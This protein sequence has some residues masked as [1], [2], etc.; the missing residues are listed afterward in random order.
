MQQLARFVLLHTVYVPKAPGCRA[1]AALGFT[2][3]M[4]TIERLP[5]QPR[6]LSRVE[7]KALCGEVYQGNS[8]AAQEG[9]DI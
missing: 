6:T 5:R 9:M 2:P 4:A 8:S 3:H 7:Q 1:Q